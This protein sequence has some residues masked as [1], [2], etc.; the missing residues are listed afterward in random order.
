MQ[1]VFEDSTLRP[2]RK[3]VMLSIADNANDTGVA[4]P[5]I[6][7][8]KNKTG[9]STGAVN[10]NIKWLCGNGYLFKKNRSRKKGG[11]SSNK[12]LIYPL[13]NKSILDEEDYLIFEDLYTQIPSDVVPPQIPSDVIGVDTQIP[14]DEQESEPSLNY[15]HHLDKFD[16]KKSLLDKGLSKQLVNDF[17]LVRKNKKAS[18]TQT[19]FSKIEREIIKSKKGWEY[20]ITLCTEKDW[21]GFESSWLNNIKDTSCVDPNDQSTWERVEA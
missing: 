17:M 21:K 3:L 11:R 8:I 7:T 4:F 1:K 16:F 5:S 9:L 10:D 20:C 14:S 12:Y 2:T 18:N 19:A 15:N 6:N 13:E